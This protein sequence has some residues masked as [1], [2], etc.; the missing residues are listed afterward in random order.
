MSLDRMQEN[1][2]RGGIKH[3][4]QFE[5]E[6]FRSTLSYSSFHWLPSA[7]LTTQPS[8]RRRFDDEYLISDSRFISELRV[9]WRGFCAHRRHFKKPG[10]ISFCRH[11]CPFSP[12]SHF[13]WR[14]QPAERND[15]REDICADVLPEANT[16]RNLKPVSS[17]KVQSWFHFLLLSWC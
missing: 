10:S 13:V 2:V 9:G 4:N 5:W 12:G 15:W 3:Q 11:V 16:L 8:P 6:D 7:G 1:D 17:L 14:R